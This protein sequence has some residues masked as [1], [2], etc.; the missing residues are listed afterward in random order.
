VKLPNDLKA[1]VPVLVLPAIVALALFHLYGPL[2]SHDP[3]VDIDRAIDADVRCHA[4]C[5]AAGWGSLNAF[6]SPRHAR[7][8]CQDINPHG[9]INNDFEGYRILRPSD[10]P[11]GGTP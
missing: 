3:N 4:R 2:P 9:Y 10:I 8:M 6:Y 7:C 11:D 5:A 1:A